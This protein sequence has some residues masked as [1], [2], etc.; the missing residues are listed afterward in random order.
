MKD[1]LVYLLS[2]IVDKPEAVTV[3]ESQEES[4]TILTIHADQADIGKIIGKNGRI[5]KAIRDVTKLIATKKNVYVDV[6]L[7]E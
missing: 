3:E 5:I 2:H 4:R 7:A 1:T 6:V